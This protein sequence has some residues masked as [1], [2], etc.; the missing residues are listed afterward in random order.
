MTR[1]QAFLHSARGW[2]ARRDAPP[3]AAARSLRRRL[4]R[5]DQPLPHSLDA[6]Y[7]HFY[8]GHIGGGLGRHL[9]AA[10][11]G[12]GMDASYV[13]EADTEALRLAGATCSGKECLPYQLI[14]GT[15]ARFLRDAAP[16][17]DGEK[18]MFLSAGS[19]FQACRAHLFPLAQQLVLDE[20]G[21]RVDVADFSLVTSNVRM[22]PVVWT[23]LVA[24]D[25]LNML[26]FHTLAEERERGAADALFEAYST[27]LERRLEQ[28][29][30]DA[31]LAGNIAGA[32][33]F[34]G[35][36]EELLARASRA[37]LELPRTPVAGAARRVPV[38]RHL[39]ARGRVGQRRPAAQARR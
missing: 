11:R 3:D 30:P 32:V 36:V 24:V 9:A 10:M 20:L 37:F 33:R 38:R 14:W 4:A 12:A 31:G 21:R 15:L 23:A 6:G 16:A 34:C 26:R 29:R 19:G 8:F 35:E 22:M 27:E 39:P 7:D 28:P 17:A 18:V 2:R 25:L 5:Y 1:V 13:G